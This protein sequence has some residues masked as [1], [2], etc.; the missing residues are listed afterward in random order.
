MAHAAA[1]GGSKNRSLKNYINRERKTKRS[2][3]LH[4]RGPAR[5]DL[6]GANIAGVVYIIIINLTGALLSR[7]TI[8]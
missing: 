7:L 3:Q 4:Q 5:G 6:G 2:A 8:A 1:A